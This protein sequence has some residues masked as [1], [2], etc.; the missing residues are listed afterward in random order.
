MDFL[1]PER[2]PVC[3]PPPILE[4]SLPASLRPDLDGDKAGAATRELCRGD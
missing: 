1:A 3:D 2:L 4:S